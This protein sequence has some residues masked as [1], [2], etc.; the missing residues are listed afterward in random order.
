MAT[1][2]QVQAIRNGGYLDEFS[3]LAPCFLIR[4]KLKGSEF[5]DAPLIRDNK[6]RPSA[7]ASILQDVYLYLFN[8]VLELV[9][10]CSCVPRRIRFPARTVFATSS[11]FHF[12]SVIKDCQPASHPYWCCYGGITTSTEIQ[13]SWFVAVIGQGL[14]F[15]SVFNEYTSLSLVRCIEGTCNLKYAA[16]SLHTSATFFLRELVM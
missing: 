3:R 13:L 5:T 8:V 7:A 12:I 4:R 11:P 2:C 9:K 16:S 10:L 14:F 1:T 15:F 6:Q